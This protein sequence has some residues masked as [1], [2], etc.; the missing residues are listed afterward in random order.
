MS[1][2]IAKEVVETLTKKETFNL[3]DFVTSKVQFPTKEVKVSLDYALGMEAQELAEEIATLD[4]VRTG[5]QSADEGITG[6]ET[7]ELDAEIVEKT[8]E[9]VELV[10]RYNAASLTFVLRGVAP[11]L[12]RVLDRKYRNEF[13]PEKGATDDEKQELFIQQSAKVDIDTVRNSIVSVITPD[14]RIMEGSPPF[15]DV[16]SIFDNAPAH[17]WNA[18]KELSEKLTFANH[19]FAQVASDAD[20]LP[21]SS[22]SQ[23]TEDTSSPSELRSVTD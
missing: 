3:K 20:F 14:G 10:E 7:P 4:A 6:A 23:E 2:D 9:L 8:E 11:A 21:P 17:E 22:A 19:A 16:E 13:R 18:L 15:E 12:W 5:M 1:T